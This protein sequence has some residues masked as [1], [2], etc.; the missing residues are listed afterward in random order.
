MEQYHSTFKPEPSPHMGALHEA[1]SQTIGSGAMAPPPA[2]LPIITEEMNII[3]SNLHGLVQDVTDMHR[4]L[5]DAQSPFDRTLETPMADA[6]PARPPSIQSRLVDV[7]RAISII[8]ETV[9]SIRSNI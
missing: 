5:V 2:G 8:A 4:A 1:Q 3:E 9:A 6:P 7:N